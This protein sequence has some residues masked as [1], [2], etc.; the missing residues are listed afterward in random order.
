[1]DHDG[2]RMGGRPGGQPTLA[3]VIPVRG[4]RGYLARCLRSIEAQSVPPDEL[5]VVDN[6]ENGDLR[7][8][9][10]RYRFRTIEEPVA[11]IPAATAT[12]FDATSADVLARI[13]A[14]SVLPPHWVRAAR[15]RF[16]DPAVEAV[17]GW[18]WMPNAPRLVSQLSV[19]AYLGAYTLAAGL[20]LGHRPLWGSSMLI[21]RRLWTVARARF[22]RHDQHVHDDLDLSV[23][24]PPGTR[25]I[26]DRRLSVGVSSRQF[27]DA[28]KLRRYVAMA[29]HTFVK[30]WPRELPPFRSVRIIRARMARR[31]RPNPAGRGPAGP[32]PAGP[33]PAPRAPRSG[34]PDSRRPRP[35]RRG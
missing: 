18:A 28:A 29:V 27:R 22:C 25:V 4:D 3:I 32:G 15:E 30:H 2:G 24:L 17:T 35:S 21:R 19:A 7:D 11:G 14:D 26:R 1:M 10:A 33:G 23:H 6:G 16:T 8:L 9:A 13:D 5:I 31:R 20:G 12:G 34:V